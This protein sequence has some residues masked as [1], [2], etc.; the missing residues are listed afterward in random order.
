MWQFHLSNLLEID[1][2]EH[3]YAFDVFKET[4]KIQSDKISY[5]TRLEDFEMLDYDFVDIVAPTQFHFQYLEK[6]ISLWKDIFVEKP[7]VSNKNELDELEIL[8]KRIWY[9]WKIWI[10]FIERFNVVAKFLRDEILSRGTPKQVECFRYNPAS[11]RIWETGVTED[12]MIHD[13]DLM[14]YFFPN[15]KISIAGKNI[16]TE[17]ST[18][19]LYTEETNIILSANRITQQKIREVKLYYKDV[20]IVWNLMPGKVDFFHKPETYLSQKWQDLSISYMVDEKIL[21]KNDQ[22]KEE[23]KEFCSV[24]NGWKFDILTDYSGAYNWFLTLYKILH[25]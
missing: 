25:S 7:I 17:T 9:E 10:G 5:S 8:I 2:I 11:G 12:L 23:L 6:F 22:L 18:V 14:H 20:T 24:V 21:V 3:I 16:N 19:L 13:I 1:E 4:F 15:Q